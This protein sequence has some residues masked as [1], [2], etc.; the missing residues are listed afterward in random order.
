MCIPS[1]ELC[2]CLYIYIWFS[3]QNLQGETLSFILIT[4]IYNQERQLCVQVA[5]CMISYSPQRN[6]LIYC[7]SSEKEEQQDIER[8]RQWHWH[9]QFNFRKYLMSLWLLG[10]ISH[11][12]PPQKNY[13]L[14]HFFH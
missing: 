9:F 8:R 1:T 7:N 14:T 13:F 2:V 12:P 3:D 5:N 4:L 10:I 6:N 11:P